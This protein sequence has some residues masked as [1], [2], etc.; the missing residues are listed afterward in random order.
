MTTHYAVSATQLGVT[1]SAPQDFLGYVVVK[2]HQTYCNLSC[3]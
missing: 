1:K 3:R 2:L